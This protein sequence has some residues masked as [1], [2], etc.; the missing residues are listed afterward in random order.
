MAKLN[1]I[2]CL[3][4]FGASCGLNAGNAVL[5]PNGK[6]KSSDST[7]YATLWNK[8]CADKTGTSERS[9]KYAEVKNRTSQIRPLKE[10]SMTI[11]E[12]NFD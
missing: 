6:F 10:Q 11:E 8:E 12:A 1:S 3:D 7:G 5:A 9:I 4:Q 2:A